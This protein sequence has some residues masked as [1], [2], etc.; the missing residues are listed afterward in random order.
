MEEQ[1][2]ENSI[3]YAI[4]N[5]K[6]NGA[7]LTSGNKDKANTMTISWAGIGYLWKKDVFIIVISNIR[8]TKEF[9]DNENTFTI[10]IPY[11]ENMKEELDFCGHN[12]GRHINKE[13][14][15]NVKFLKS[16]EVNSPIVDGCN[17]YYECKVLFKQNIDVT[18]IGKDIIYN[19]EE[20][21]HTMYF[22]EIVGS[23]Y[24][25]NI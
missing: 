24:L 7:F 14:A 10:S 20:A 3:D 1:N 21:E 9:I 5:I 12:S 17:M 2:Y 18:E 8:Y 11:E 19:E 6:N 15:A 25:N 13:K 16:K 4:R 23:Y 22:G